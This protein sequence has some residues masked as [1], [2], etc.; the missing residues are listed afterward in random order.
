VTPALA[1]GLQFA[2]LLLLVSAI[3]WAYRRVELE[4]H[5]YDPRMAKHAR[6]VEMEQENHSTFPGGQ[7]YL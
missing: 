6:R 3:W 2:V 5:G 7:R 4:K 1:I